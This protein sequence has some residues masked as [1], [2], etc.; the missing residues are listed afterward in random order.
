MSSHNQRAGNSGLLQ[1]HCQYLSAINSNMEIATRSIN[2][3]LWLLKT[4]TLTGFIKKI[5]FET[6]SAYFLT[7]IHFKQY[8][9]NIY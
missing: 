4:Q 8:K 9:L 5:D 2:T 1:G 6:A 3:V 7:H